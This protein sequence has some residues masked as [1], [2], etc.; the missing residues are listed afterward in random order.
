MT[1]VPLPVFGNLPQGTVSSG[2]TGT[3]AAGTGE[4]W[5]VNVTTAFPVALAVPAGTTGVIALNEVG[6]VRSAVCV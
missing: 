4:T 2:G 1:A 5:T 6:A 3:P